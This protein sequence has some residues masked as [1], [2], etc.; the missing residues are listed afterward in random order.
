M[1]KLTKS[2]YTPAEVRQELAA[3]LQEKIDSYGSQLRKLRE[4][5]VGRTA[6]AKGDLCLLC[7]QLPVKC[8][9]IST[10]AKSLPYGASSS[11]RAQRAADNTSQRPFM[12]HIDVDGANREL[13]SFKS[14][15]PK[16]SPRSGKGAVSG[17]IPNAKA[18]KAPKRKLPRLKKTALKKHAPASPLVDPRNP[19]DHPAIL[20]AAAAA[21]P[22]ASGIPGKQPVGAGGGDAFKVPHPATT[23]SLNDVRQLAPAAANATK[24]KAA[25]PAVKAPA[26][27]PPAPAAPPVAMPKTSAHPDT[28]ASLGAVA[29]MAP[30]A[31]WKGAGLPSLKA[32]LQNVQAA[33]ALAPKAAPAAAPRIQAPPALG[34]AV[35][36]APTLAATKGAQ[37]LAD[38]KRAAGVGI[39]NNIASRLPHRAPTTPN[40]AKQQLTADKRAGGVGFLNNL[41][42]RFG[43]KAPAAAAPTPGV[44]PAQPTAAPVQS[45]RFHGALPLQRSEPEAKKVKVKLNVDHASAAKA[46]K[47]FALDKCAMCSKS[48]HAG[49]CK[50]EMPAP[51]EGLSSMNHNRRM[52]RAMPV[53]VAGRRQG[54]KKRRAR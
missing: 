54:V 24:D 7:A 38:D 46:K 48:E 36:N 1:P 3:L 50:E 8:S 35:R 22:P 6:L 25:L 51:T 37:Q 41:L 33:H 40:G 5:E 28:K 49:M 18:E 34:A 15:V 2:E 21:K 4:R 12:G 9:C 17:E 14:V 42:S 44:A 53:K 20:A 13:G 52:L 11:A 29:A 31:A 19:K 27:K 26:A 23:A 39:V 43:R 10:L 32:K 47:A 16:T 45:K 30:N